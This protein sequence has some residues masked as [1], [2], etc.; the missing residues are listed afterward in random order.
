MQERKHFFN[1]PFMCLL[2]IVAFFFTIYLEEVGKNK[3]AASALW[4]I[5]IAYPLIKSFPLSEWNSKRKTNNLS[6][7]SNDEKPMA[8]IFTDV[9]NEIAKI[10]FQNSMTRYRE[11]KKNHSRLSDHTNEHFIEKECGLL[12]DCFITGEQF[13]F[14]YHTGIMENHF[15]TE[16]SSYRIL[17]K[18]LYLLKHKAGEINVIEEKVIGVRNFQ[19]IFSEVMERYVQV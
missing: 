8:E 4:L 2:Y 14:H 9:D 10:K 19:I 15:W 7:Y 16:F 6:K 18:K 13:I 3:Q 17:G 12:K 11:I 5:A 1:L